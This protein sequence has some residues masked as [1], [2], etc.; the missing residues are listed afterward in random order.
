MSKK[1]SPGG[2]YKVGY[3]KPP[4]ENQFKKGQSG[5]R[6]GRPKGASNKVTD[7]SLYA[8]FDQEMS[9]EVSIMKG[10]QKITMTTANVVIRSLTQ[11]AMNG[12][13]RAAT[14]VLEHKKTMDEKGWSEQARLAK[15][16][17]ADFEALLLAMTDEQYD[18]YRK[19][20]KR[21]NEIIQ[22]SPSPTQQAR[23]G[24]PKKPTDPD[25]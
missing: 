15:Q 17:E 23:L 9:R 18:E 4:K 13:T 24:G 8:L 1:K 20:L 21:I 2:R 14:I 10:D 7:N 3:C 6:R 16:Q 25:Q 5:N 22:P 11:S 12:N 19:L